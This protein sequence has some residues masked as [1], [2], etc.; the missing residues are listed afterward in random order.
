MCVRGFG[1]QARKPSTACQIPWIPEDEMKPRDMCKPSRAWDCPWG[2]RQ[3]TCPCTRWVNR[4]LA[5]CVFFQSPPCEM[6]QVE[7]KIVS[8]QRYWGGERPW[9]GDESEVEKD[10]VI[11]V[12][13]FREIS[14]RENKEKQITKEDTTDYQTSNAAI[15]WTLKIYVRFLKRIP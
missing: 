11:F 7:G 8:I 15:R 14:R 12:R 6:V 4:G 5:T 1:F 3:L 13:E 9:R 10:W 2:A